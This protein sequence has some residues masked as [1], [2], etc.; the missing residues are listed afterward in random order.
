MY[1]SLCVC[2]RYCRFRGVILCLFA[3]AFAFAF[4]PRCCTELWPNARTR[5]GHSQ[6]TETKHKRRRQHKQHKQNTT[7]HT[8]TSMPRQA[9]RWAWRL[10]FGVFWFGESVLCRRCRQCV[11]EGAQH[12]APPPHSTWESNIGGD[13]PHST[14]LCIGGCACSARLFLL[15]VVCCVC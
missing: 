14:S 7:T 6:P 8:H 1:Y 11:C 3:F 15:R 10:C 4:G 2:H 5:F 12:V 9:G 13:E